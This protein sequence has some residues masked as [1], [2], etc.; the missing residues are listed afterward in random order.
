MPVGA[1]LAGI[2]ALAQLFLAG[3][4]LFS[5]QGGRGNGKMRGVLLGKAERILSP[6][7]LSR[8]AM[9]VL[10]VCASLLPAAEAGAEALIHV[11]E[12]KRPDIPGLV[13]APDDPLPNLTARSAVV[14]DA[15]SRQVIYSRD[16]DARRFPAST[17]KIMTLIVALEKGNLDDMVTVGKNAEGTEGSTLWLVKGEKIRLHELLYG[18]MLHSGN[19]ATV[20]VAEH[21]AGSVEAFA[22][23]MTGKAHEIG[24]KDTNFVNANGLPDDNHYTTA[25]D[26]ALITAYGYSLPEFEQIVSTK[27]INFDWVHDDTHRLRNENQ[28][29]WYYRGANGVKTG[30]TEKAGR[31]LVTGA[32]EDGLQLISVV[33]DSTYMWNDSIA[34]L[35]YGFSHVKATTLIKEDAPYARVAISGSKKSVIPVYA[36]H[37]VTVADPVKLGEKYELRPELPDVL[38]APVEKGDVVGR[39]DVLLEGKVIASVDLLAGDSA[40]KKSF[41]RTVERF[42]KNLLKGI[43]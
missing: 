32:R 36:A 37:E 9:A 31:C 13:I 22:R 2:F 43:L 17:T 23:L 10:F 35:D 18:M 26:L 11:Q 4:R 15:A 1:K 8:I 25:Y 38:P 33:L 7:A 19:D 12:M 5:L 39:A 42:L 28:M 21:I 29:L 40:E 3:N 6:I 24:A 16:M 27:E 34:L 14:M 41:F 20:A 30:Y